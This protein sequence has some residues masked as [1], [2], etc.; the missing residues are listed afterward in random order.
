MKLLTSQ[1]YAGEVMYRSLLEDERKCGTFIWEEIGVKPFDEL[2]VSWSAERPVKG[3]YL[4]QVS[5]LTLEW[6]PWLDYAL[7]SSEEQ[8]TFK[9]KLPKLSIQVYQ[10]VVEVLG[11]KARGFRIRVIA[12]ENTSLENF[13]TLYISSI[14]RDH[15]SITFIPLEK[16]AV[17][18]KVNGLSQ[19]ALLDERRQR[20]C[21]PT[22]TTAVIN[23]LEDSLNLSPLEFANSVVD[24]AFDIYGNWILNTA[25]AAHILGKSWHCFVARMNSF[26]Q[27]IDQLMKGYP[28]VASIKGDLKG[29]A[30]PYEFG[31]LIVVTGYDSESRQVSCMDPAFSTN[32]STCIK[33]ALNEF[34]TAWRRRQGLAY[35]FQPALF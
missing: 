34:L 7:W 4:I 2:I 35:I 28:V 16:I 32:N 8:H 18:L 14:D 20:L 17:D 12:N 30:L 26:N 6:S 10:D 5:L 1:G 22:S 24:S 15:H 25:Q 19:M 13:R 9:K 29:G 31:H 3:S 27:I 23:F 33:Y 21:S 11:D